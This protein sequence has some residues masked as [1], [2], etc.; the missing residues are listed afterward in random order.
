MFGFVTHPNLRTVKL[1]MAM[2]V[3]YYRVKSGRNAGIIVAFGEWPARILKHR[4][5]KNQITMRVTTP[6]E[7]DWLSDCMRLQAIHYKSAHDLLEDEQNIIKGM[8]LEYVKIAC[9]NECA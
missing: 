3:R 7:D 8:V 2:Y 5:W 6:E 1:I 9:L 4:G